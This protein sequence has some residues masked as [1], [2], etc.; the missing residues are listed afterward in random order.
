MR[1]LCQPGAEAGAR[2]RARDTRRSP[3]QGSSHEPT[4]YH[5][6]A[7]AQADRTPPATNPPHRPRAPDSATPPQC[8]QRG[9]LLLLAVAALTC[10]LWSAA[11]PAAAGVPYVPEEASSIQPAPTITHGPTDLPRIALTFDDNYDLPRGYR[12]LDVLKE[13]KVPATVFVIGHYQDLGPDLSHRLAADGLEIGDHTRS[14]ADVTSL[15]WRALQIEIGDG[16]RTFAELTGRPTAPL[17]RPP[18]GYTNEVAATAVA[19]QGF[20][21]VVLWDIETNDWRGASAAAI[22][23]AVLS[24]AH[25][26]AI[27][28]MHLA[29]PHTAEALP[30]VI[31]GL[32][33]RG[34]ELV[35]VTDL[36]KGD[37]RF[38]DVDP[39]TAEGQTILR[40]VEAGYLSGVDDD[41]FGPLDP[42]TRA[43][44]GRAAVLATGAAGSTGSTDST[45]YVSAAE[46]AGLLPP[47]RAGSAT[48]PPPV[49]STA[50]S[51]PRRSLGWP[52]PRDTEPK[53][54]PPRPAGAPPRPSPT[55]PR[56]P[57]TT[58]GWR[59]ISG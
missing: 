42:L 24:Q 36:L 18:G 28:L 25:N 34:Y 41:Y 31:S 58:C 27:V 55:Y 26:G 7:H 39:A 32:R 53:T 12:T 5:S 43:D 59:S 15:S 19:A 20:R 49:P 17:F 16:T 56:K 54:P 14:H 3:T 51:S 30:G 40:A 9:A 38:V 46:A 35:T 10:T 29:A 48:M 47:P 13:M 22:T 6:R 33:Q 21:S 37:R 45:D 1:S 8:P 2:N 52:G 50:C 4:K 11:G 23:D 57:P 44:L